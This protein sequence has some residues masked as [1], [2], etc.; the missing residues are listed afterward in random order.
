[1]ASTG[2]IAAA[3]AFLAGPGSGAVAGQV[4]QPSGGVTG[5][6]A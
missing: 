6:R 3:V 2:D 5:T 1:M 4:P